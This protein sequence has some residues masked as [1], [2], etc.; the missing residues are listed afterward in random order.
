[1]TSARCTSKRW[2]MHNRCPRWR[3][4]ILTF[5]ALRYYDPDKVLPNHDDPLLFISSHDVALT[6]LEQLGTPRLD[7]RRCMISLFDHSTQYINAEGTETLSLQDD[8]THEPG[9]DLWLTLTPIPKDNGC[10]YCRPGCQSAHRYF[11]IFKW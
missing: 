3:D 11:V 10:R 4:C 6:A 5:T 9:D 2:R 1:M 8:S 7:I